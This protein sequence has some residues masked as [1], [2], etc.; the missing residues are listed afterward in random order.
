MITSLFEN[1][2]NQ[3][4]DA[5]TCNT[6]KNLPNLVVEYHLCEVIFRCETKY[7]QQFDSCLN[8]FLTRQITNEQRT[9][10]LNTISCRFASFKCKSTFKYQQVKLDS[11]I[12]ENSEYNLVLS[13]NHANAS[14]RANAFEFIL[15]KLSLATKSNTQQKSFLNT[16]DE[17]FVREQME[18]KF[19]SETS[20]EVLEALLKFD[21]SLT[22]YFSLEELVENEDY[23]LKL[24]RSDMISAGVD[25]SDDSKEM[26]EFRQAMNKSLLNCRSQVVDLIFNSLYKKVSALW[27]N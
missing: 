11:S 15:S 9:Y 7:P 23:L 22:R 1:L 8:T 12:T 21:L 2:I 27:S 10:F 19:S 25:L 16:I 5:S 24:F 26:N 3:V 17:T 6:N 4:L 14:I 13:L 18:M 20:P